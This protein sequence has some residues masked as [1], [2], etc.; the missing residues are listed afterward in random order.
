MAID[1]ACRFE[2][3]PQA[4]SAAAVAPIAMIAAPRPTSRPLRCVRANHTMPVR[5]RS[6]ATKKFSR[7]P[8]M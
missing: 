6:T 8:R 5:Q 2:A 1:S 7:S 3:P 4:P